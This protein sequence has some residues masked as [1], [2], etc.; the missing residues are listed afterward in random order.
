[1]LSTQLVGAP[2]S[3][4]PLR[5]SSLV[6]LARPR[7]NAPIQTERAFGP[8]YAFNLPYCTALVLS[9][10]SQAGALLDKGQD[11]CQATINPGTRKCPDDL[12]C[13]EGTLIHHLYPFACRYLIFV[14]PPQPA[15]EVRCQW[16][17]VR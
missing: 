4:A 2:P 1:M 9:T 11:N 7:C 13:N 17:E 12:E 6:S 5:L 10:K 16:D 3:L 8:T 15:P 14:P